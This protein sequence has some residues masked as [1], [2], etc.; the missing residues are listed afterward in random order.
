MIVNS[1][2]FALA[3]CPVIVNN[4]RNISNFVE[5]GVNGFLIKDLYLMEIIKTLKKLAQ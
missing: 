2:A 5:N 3:G 1:N 4:T